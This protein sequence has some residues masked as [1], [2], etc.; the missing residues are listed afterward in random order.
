[1][2][3]WMCGWKDVCVCMHACVCMCM[4]VCLCVDVWVNG[5]SIVRAFPPFSVSTSQP[6]FILLFPLLHSHLVQIFWTFAGTH[7][8]PSAA[9]RTKIH[10]TSRSAS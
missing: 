8:R 7:R 4:H 5:S 6:Y 10:S 3:G 1:M 2:G 9:S